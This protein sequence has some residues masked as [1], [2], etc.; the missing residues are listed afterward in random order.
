MIKQINKRQRAAGIPFFVLAFFL[1]TAFTPSFSSASDLA[2]KKSH[3]RLGSSL[4]GA[5][6]SNITLNA[7]GVSDGSGLGGLFFNYDY[8]PNDNLLFKI[9]YKG[10]GERYLNE[11]DDH[12]AAHA[13][14]LTSGYRPL[15]SLYLSVDAGFEQVSYPGYELYSYEGGYGKAAGRW[16][17]GDS[18]T[19]RFSYKARKDRFPDYDLDNS[20]QRIDLAWEEG[21]GD[22]ELRLP[23]VFELI[24]Y[25]ERFILDSDG[26]PTTTLG[27]TRYLKV[28]PGLRFWIGFNLRVDAALAWEYNDTDD[29]WYY[30][31][32]TGVPDPSINS[33]LVRHFNAYSALK[34]GIKLRW[35]PGNNLS[36]YGRLAAGKR[37]YSE[38][39]AYDEND[40]PV[41][42]LQEDIY[43]LSSL[44][45]AWRF[46]RT[47]ELS[48]LYLWI[49]Q[50]SNDTLWDYDAH[51]V[52]VR[53]SF[54]WESE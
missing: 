10:A 22:L 54:W 20:S 29:T 21:L 11:T 2:P 5:W 47:M 48:A 15:D 23:L 8:F 24:H 53:I 33:E 45:T 42:E 4:G 16:E 36:I 44:E 40:L 30:E 50:S 46:S 41:G 12:H 34:G 43:F 51:R 7:L 6:S 32:P 1:G 14:M 27:S 3:L 25:D 13:L 31:G 37:D 18:S 38:R 52:E 49:N 35:T 28:E 17:I 19:L 9:K 26:Q 39:P